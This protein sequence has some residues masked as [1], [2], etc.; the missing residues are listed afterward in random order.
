MLRLLH[1]HL[2]SKL[3]LPR[4]PVLIGSLPLHHAWNSAPSPSSR[5][6]SSSERAE[7]MF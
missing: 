3:V 5:P 1:L 7:P 6:P 2:R 4:L